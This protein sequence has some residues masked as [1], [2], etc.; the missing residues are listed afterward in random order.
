MHFIQDQELWY[1]EACDQRREDTLFGVLE[2]DNVSVW[3][4]AIVPFM[5]SA[6][7][8]AANRWPFAEGKVEAVRVAEACLGH[9]GFNIKGRCRAGGWSGGNWGASVSSMGVLLPASS[10]A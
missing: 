9:G 6:N 7:M 3:A 4:P 2:T 5:S 8:P 10:V 1:R